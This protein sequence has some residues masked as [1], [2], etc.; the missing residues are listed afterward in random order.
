M[1]KGCENAQV[2][3]L[4]TK[5]IR[6]PNRISKWRWTDKDEKQGKNDDGGCE[7]PVSVQNQMQKPFFLQD[8]KDLPAQSQKN[9][10]T[11]CCS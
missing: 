4:D 5:H 8:D 9:A 11:I 3:Q 1:M 2:S 7:V 6:N 10:P